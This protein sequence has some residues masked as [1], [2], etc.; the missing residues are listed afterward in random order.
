MVNPDAVETERIIRKS[1][2]AARASGVGL[3]VLR[4]HNDAEIEQAFAA[5]AQARDGGLVA[6]VD[7]SA[8]GV[9]SLRHSRQST[10]LR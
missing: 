2:D 9:S 10:A 6:G 5:I 7:A 1:Q 8:A 4:A 3:H